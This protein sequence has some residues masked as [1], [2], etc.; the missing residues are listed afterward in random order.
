M[1]SMSNT[2]YQKISVALLTIVIT[3]VQFSFAFA[4]PINAEKLVDLT[5]QSRSQNGLKTLKINYELELAAQNKAQNMLEYDYFEHYSPYGLSPWDFIKESGYNYIV[6]GENLAMDFKTSEGIHSA[7]M[8]SPLHKKNILKPEF[9]D[10]GIATV[11]GEFNNYQTTMVVQMFGKITTKTSIFDSL[12][13]KIS[14]W[15]LGL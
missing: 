9:E 14:S 3:L 15:L 4:T 11:K 10:I 7:W 13:Y 6:A 2:I 5:N 8:N 1:K 12:I